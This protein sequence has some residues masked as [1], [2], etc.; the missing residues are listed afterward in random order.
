MKCY[1]VLKTFNEKEFNVYSKLGHNH[2]VNS[3]NHETVDVVIPKDPI[4]YG[5][6]RQVG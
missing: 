3:E 1:V 4:F 5:G 6:S 2:V